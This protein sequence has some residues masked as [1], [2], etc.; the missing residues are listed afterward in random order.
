MKRHDLQS[1]A[2]F[3][4][5]YKRLYKISILCLKYKIKWEMQFS[6]EICRN[7]AQIVKLTQ[8]DYFPLETGMNM[9]VKTFPAY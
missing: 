1:L 4:R 5:I 9:A 2:N 8:H 7:L 3:S 6:V